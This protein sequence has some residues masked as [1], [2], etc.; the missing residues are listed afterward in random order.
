MD[1]SRETSEALSHYTDRLLKWNAKINL[2]G[3]STQS[4]IWDRHIEDSLQIFEAAPEA[5]TWADLGSGGGLPGLVV[6]IVAKEQNPELEITLVESD[7]RKASFCRSIAQDLSLNLRVIA[8]RIE[9]VPPLNAD[10]LSARALAPLNVLLVHTEMHRMPSGTAIFPKG[11]NW[12]AEVTE[13]LASWRFAFEKIP[14]RTRS[15]A[16][17]LKIGEISRA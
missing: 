3:R 5:K 6:G 11:E 12:E 1:V 15:N 9:S 17:I 13:S 16:V 8:E 2:I 7:K 14:S 4:D 10:I